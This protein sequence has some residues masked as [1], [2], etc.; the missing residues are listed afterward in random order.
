MAR[1]TTRRRRRNLDE[2]CGFN[3]V[4]ARSRVSPQHGCA[5]AMGSEE[6][7]ED[8]PQAG[9]IFDPLVQDLI[10]DLSID[11]DVPM[12]KSGSKPDSCE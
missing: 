5:G 7:G 8:C 3:A 9:D 4:S 2:S 11:I 12:D 6:S 10:D 1:T